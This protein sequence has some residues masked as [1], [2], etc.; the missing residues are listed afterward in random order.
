MLNKNV[1]KTVS[2]TNLFCNFGF[3]TARPWAVG[4][5]V[6]S[7]GEGGH[8]WIFTID[9]AGVSD[10]FFETR[11]YIVVPRPRLWAKKSRRDRDLNVPRLR[12]DFWNQ[13]NVFNM[14]QIFLTL[15]FGQWLFW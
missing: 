9:R 6:G 8:L 5:S 7:G 14:S 11:R 3:R 12:R 4:M 13:I 1:V 15:N 10:K 2:R